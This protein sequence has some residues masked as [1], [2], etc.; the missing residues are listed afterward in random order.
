MAR[1]TT[2]AQR[3]W[4]LYDWANSAFSTT[5]IAGFFPLFFK[6]YWAGD[7]EPTTSTFWLGAANS[8]ASLTVLMLAPVLGALSDIDRS[9]RRWLG[10]FASIGI[11]ATIGLFLIGQGQWQAAAAVYAIAVIGWS[12]ANVFY[13]A[14]L[15]TLTGPQQRHRLSSF[16]FALGYLGGGLLFLVNVMMTLKPA[17]FGLADAGEAVRYAFLSVALWWAVFALPL[18]LSR[19]NTGVVPVAKGEL[20][21]FGQRVADVMRGLAGTARSIKTNRNLALFLVGYW[22]YIDGVATIIRMAVDYGIAIGLPS[23]SLIIALLLVQFVG[24]P[25]TLVFGRISERIGARVSLLI[26]LSAYLVATIAAAAMSTAVHFYAL[27]VVLGLVQG[28]VQ[29]LSRSLFSQLIPAERAG[30]YFGFLNMLGKTAAVIGPLL[31]GVVAATTGSPRMG[32][33]SIV[34]LFAVGMV[35]LAR[36]KEPQYSGAHA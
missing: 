18:L 26:A 6:Q 32:I 23:N 30:E 21:P 36:V 29:A 4:A 22:F 24:F 16:G 17:W 31:V 2:R 5:V 20:K 1:S 28:A 12:G 25:S 8:G 27:A 33:L 13:D 11:V 34:V 19:H 9:H 14:M 10:L 15:P 7:L 35:L 3:D